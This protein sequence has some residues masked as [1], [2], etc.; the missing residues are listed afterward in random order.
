MGRSKDIDFDIIKSMSE[1]QQQQVYYTLAKRANQR[2]RDITVKAGEQSGAVTKAVK[3]LQEQQGRSTFKQSKKLTA[4][5][6]KANLEALETFYNSKSATLPGLRAIQ[7]QRVETLSNKIETE[8]DNR[9]IAEKY[10]DLMASSDGRQK[11]YD[12]VSSQQFKNLSKY[13][14]SDQVIQDFVD[15][16]TTEIHEAKQG[17][18]LAKISKQF[19][20]PIDNLRKLNEDFENKNMDEPIAPN[21]KVI[22]HGSFTLDEIM[23]QYEEFMNNELTFEQVAE[24]RRGGG[25]L[26]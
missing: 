23:Q 20:I 17:D 4:I 19:D 2:F 5:E 12:F 14:D 11:F 18:T 7:T 3:W 16:N 10:R 6:L 24:R 8:L 22:L 13:A 15:A 1:E 9:T 25:M 21:T 26:N